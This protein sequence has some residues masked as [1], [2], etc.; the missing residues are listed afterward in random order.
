MSEQPNQPADPGS[1]PVIPPWGRP[2]AVTTAGVFFISLAFPV[3]ASLS[4][5]TAAFPKWWGIADVSLAFV[6]ATLTFVIFGL[7]RGKVN[8]RAEDTSYRGYRI[9][10]RNIRDDGRV[11]RRWRSDY[12][13]QWIT[14][15]CL[16]SLVAFVLFARVAYCA[17]RCPQ[18]AVIIA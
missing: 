17:R 8:K 5:D 3:I 16:A 14:G 10:S 7:T 1:T 18:G 13:D 11:P 9:D 4:K 2:F 12:L 6:L 15:H